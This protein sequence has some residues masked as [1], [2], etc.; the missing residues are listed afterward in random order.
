M[1]AAAESRA[2]CTG[3]C[4]EV[5]RSRE[6]FNQCS[7]LFALS[8]VR[9]HRLNF[10]LVDAGISFRFLADNGNV[11][12][13]VYLFST[14]KLIRVLAV[15]RSQGLSIRAYAADNLPVMVTKPKI[16]RGCACSR[17]NRGSD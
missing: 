12:A 6:Y 7:L 15:V 3:L 17:C 16:Q 13:R 10:Q 14:R 9:L 2:H 4:A 5:S 11:F 1:A 8:Q